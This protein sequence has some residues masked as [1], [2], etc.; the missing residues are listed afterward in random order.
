M[1]KNLA[2]VLKDF[3][4]RKILVIGDIMLD[5]IT[6]GNIER[7]NPEQPASHLIKIY[8]DKNYNL[9][10]AANVANNVVALGAFCGLYGVIGND[11]YGEEIKQICKEKKIDLMGFKDGK[12]SIVKQRII[13]HGQQIV[14]LDYGENNLE[15]ISQEIQ[16]SI[17]KKLKKDIIEYDFA[18]L[19]DYN[20]SLFSEKLAQGII[21]LARSNGI[22]TL[23]DPKPDN[24]DFFRNCTVISPNK[25][26]AERITGIRYSNGDD[27]LKKIGEVLSKRINSKY[28]IIT[29]GE[30]GMFS[31]HNGKSTYMKTKAR[32]VADP[33]GAGDTFAATL[34]LGLASKLNID[35][36]ARLA[37][38]A[39]G[40]VVEKVGTAT[41]TIEEIKR[42]LE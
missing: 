5:R 37:N 15:K 34:G 7:V 23:A 17:L 32:R 20:K 22:Q 31:Y 2:R 35:D 10:G 12:P 40:I 13:A 29:C 3:E 8:S 26:E 14:R 9:G 30:D 1:T 24:I 33:T 11:S 16:D 42:Y 41:P 38:C 36:A 21:D 28:V 18:I 39:A 4:K 6:L 27:V 25:E 19:S